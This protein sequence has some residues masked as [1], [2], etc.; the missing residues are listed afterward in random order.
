MGLSH[1][2]AT[3]MMATQRWYRGF[4]LRAAID[5]YGPCVDPAEHGTVPLLVLAGEADDWGDPAARCR[6]YATAIG[7]GEP[8]E[9][10]TYPGVHHAFDNP[11]MV[12]AMSNEHLLLYDKAAAEDSFVR[13]HD[14]LNNWVRR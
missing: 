14:F 8:I 13:V 10:R 7:I 2:G 11:D 5:Y 9:V 4:G 6:A 1:G 3:A 12:G